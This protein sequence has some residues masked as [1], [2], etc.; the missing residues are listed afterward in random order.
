MPE[1][2]NVSVNEK[3]GGEI[4]LL[5]DVLAD[6]QEDP[7]GARHNNFAAGKSMAAL[8]TIPTEFVRK[9]RP[10]VAPGTTPIITDLSVS[11]RTRSEQ[12]FRLLTTDGAR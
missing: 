4:Y 7:T 8:T 3:T 9:V 1:E 12:N 5:Q 11:S 2:K 6:D 10:I